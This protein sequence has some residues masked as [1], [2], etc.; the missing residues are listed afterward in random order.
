M[1][2]CLDNGLTCSHQ[3]GF[4][5]NVLQKIRSFPFSQ[6][7]H[8]RKILQEKTWANNSNST[9]FTGFWKMQS[10]QLCPLALEIPGLTLAN[11]ANARQAFQLK[12]RAWSPQ[13]LLAWIIQPFSSKLGARALEITL[14]LGRSWRFST[15]L[16]KPKFLTTGRKLSLGHSINFNRYGEQSGARQLNMKLRKTDKAANVT[17]ISTDVPGG[18]CLQNFWDWEGSCNTVLKTTCKQDQNLK[19]HHVSW[20]VLK[21]TGFL[22]KS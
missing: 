5:L 10:R 17:E 14:H 20:L 3:Q 19:S 16:S 22:C 6:W 2:E 12:G 7:M 15:V 8:K 9:Q 13:K 1:T 11:M 18:Y 4:N 21:V